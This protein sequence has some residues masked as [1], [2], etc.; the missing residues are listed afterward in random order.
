MRKS[1]ARPLQKAQLGRPP[2]EKAEKWA[3][4][5]SGILVEAAS[6]GSKLIE[7]RKYP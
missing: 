7:T 1:R 3:R 4:R 5:E 6:G 2:E